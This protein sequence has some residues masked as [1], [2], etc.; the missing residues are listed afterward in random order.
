VGELE[1]RLATL[2]LQARLAGGVGHDLNNLLTAILA[3]ADLALAE[4]LPAGVRA[5]IEEVVRAAERA[6]GLTRQLPALGRELVVAPRLLDVND[7]VAETAHAR[8]RLA[9]QVELVDRCAGGLPPVEADAG[10]LE[11]ALLALV[12]NAAEADPGRIT[13]E[14]GRDGEHVRLAV[15]DTG[16]GMNQATRARA[17][18]AYFTTKPGH[19]GLGLTSVDGIVARCG[20]HVTLESE[21]ARGTEVALLL[22]GRLEVGPPG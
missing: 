1:D 5:D 17:R 13:V 20:G 3:H 19:A 9:G 14:T 12:A 15:T 2:E 16:G 8:R 4:E 7:V 18:E 6:A 10:Q 21:P 11:R 22:P